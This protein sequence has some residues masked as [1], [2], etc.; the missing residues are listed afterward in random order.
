MH[1]PTSLD[2]HPDR[3]GGLGQRGRPGS[4][5]GR[6]NAKSDVFEGCHQGRLPARGAPHLP[7]ATVASTLEC[8]LEPRRPGVR[9]GVGGEGWGGWS[10]VA[11]ANARDQRLALRCRAGREGTG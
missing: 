9:S 4:R 1:L 10:P 8:S 11:A 3:S 7:A 5:C 6:V 2:H